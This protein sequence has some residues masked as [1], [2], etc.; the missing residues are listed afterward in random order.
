[1]EPFRLRRRGFV[2]Y[3]YAMRLLP[4]TQVVFKTKLT[5]EEVKANLLKLWAEEEVYTDNELTGGYGIKQYEHVFKANCFEFR[6]KFISV[7]PYG[8]E[9]GQ[10]GI[11][12]N[13]TIKEN[14]SETTITVT[15]EPLY[16]YLFL[17]VFICLF[18]LAVNIIILVGNQDANWLT[19]VFMVL[20]VGIAIYA[21]KFFIGNR[22]KYIRVFNK[23]FEAEDYQFL[24]K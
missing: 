20:P 15:I 8:S 17:V 6:Q 11:I 5:T 2:F 24:S 7:N 14:V 9:V 23:I 16:L 12:I 22:D 19:Y 4:Y 10:E 3:I 13:G 18:I 1:L 21:I